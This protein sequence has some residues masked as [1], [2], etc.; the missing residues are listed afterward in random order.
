MSEATG[1]ANRQTAF[2]WFRCRYHRFRLPNSPESSPTGP[3][4]C[5]MD[6][7]RRRSHITM[8]RAAAHPTDYYF[9]VE[10]SNLLASSSACNLI[11]RD[12]LVAGLRRAH[13]I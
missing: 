11:G 4:R 13:G 6:I 2:S 8:A 9:E 7:L 5:R 3:R 1:S 10:L 12:T